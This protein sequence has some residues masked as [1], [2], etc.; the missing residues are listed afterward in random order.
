MK[1]ETNK[2]IHIVLV[3]ALILMPVVNVYANQCQLS[4]NNEDNLQA[5]AVSIEMTSDI[6]PC[7]QRQTDKEKCCCDT[8]QCNC[9]LITPVYISFEF[10]KN[11]Q[12][13]VFSSLAADCSS[14]LNYVY[15]PSSLRP[16]IT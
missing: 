3:L 2:M 16:P 1:N 15:I 12:S 8:D 5:G 11:L 6:P 4:A 13:Y 14:Q 10:N 7:H 9:A